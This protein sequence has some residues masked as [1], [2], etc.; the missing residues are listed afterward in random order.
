MFVKSN[1]FLNSW[2]M[3]EFIYLF[4][5]IRDTATDPHL[6]SLE[7]TMWCEQEVGREEG[8]LLSCDW[9]GLTS[10]SRGRHNTTHV[11]TWSCCSVAFLGEFS[12]H[13]IQGIKEPL[14]V[15][16]QLGFPSSCWVDM[17]EL[18]GTG[19]NQVSDLIY[20]NCSVRFYFW[21]F[22]LV[23]YALDFFFLFTKD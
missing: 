6:T 9:G 5:E 10:L 16:C 12:N 22:L 11:K 8:W 13:F 19:A 3:L 20:I 7:L 17:E 18:L 23:F 2:S 15:C 1:E 14:K 21:T 4:A